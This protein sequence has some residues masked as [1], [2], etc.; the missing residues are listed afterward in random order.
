MCMFHV[1]KMKAD[2]FPFA[3]QLANTMNWNMTVNDFRFMINLEPQGCFVQFHGKERVGIATTI[4]FEKA[5]WFGNFILKEDTREKGAGTMLLKYSIDY[6]K[7][8]GAETI[9]LYTYPQLVKFYQRFGFEP[10]ADFS[11]LRGKAAFPA[12][13]ETLRQAERKD[14]PEIVDLDC[15]CFGANRR[16]LLEPIF[17]N[18]KNFCYI[19]TENKAITSFVFAKVYGEI[20]EVGPLICQANHQES[21]ALLL[22]NVLNRLSSLSVFMYIPK[23]EKPLLVM[24]GEM[25]FEKDFRVVRMFMGPAIAKNCI[26]APESLERG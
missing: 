10:D 8:K 19:I 24:L 12:A 13:Q 7:S 3:V 20:A 22:K 14:I 25:G 16:K 2:D 15:K 21:A 9:G 26:Y 5:G 17:L 1:E 11:V 6:L 23:K 4:S 18:R